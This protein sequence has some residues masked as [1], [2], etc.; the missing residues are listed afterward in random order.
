[1]LSNLPTRGLQ[2]HDI[3][4]T[5]FLFKCWKALS[6]FI[7]TVESKISKKSLHNYV[8]YCLLATRIDFGHHNL[9]A[10]GNVSRDLISVS[11]VSEWYS[12]YKYHCIKNRSLLPCRSLFISSWWKLIQIEV[13][14]LC[15]LNPVAD[16]KENLEMGGEG[17]TR[18]RENR[19]TLL[20]K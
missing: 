12:V 3:F 4:I 11:E 14:E 7:Q 5:T 10:T 18:I 2:S 16:M 20:Q 19:F 1:M 8:L 15:T 6:W 17:L 13:Q 9:P